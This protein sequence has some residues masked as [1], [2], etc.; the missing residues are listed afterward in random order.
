MEPA[1][2]EGDEVLLSPLDAAP[3]AGD[4]VVARGAGGGLV[5]HRVVHASGVCIITRGDACRRDDAPVPPR[6]VLLRALVKRSRGRTRRIPPAP[7]PLLRLWSGLRR[8]LAS[9]VAAPGRWW[10]ARRSSS[11]ST[12][13]AS[14]A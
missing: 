11:T 9:R 2:D 13:D 7:G 5:L 1:L 8:R 6:H 12:G 10:R 3:S 14:W 4:V